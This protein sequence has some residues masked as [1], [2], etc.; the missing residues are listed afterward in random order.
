MGEEPGEEIT[1]PLDPVPAAIVVVEMA[2]PAGGAGPTGW[3]GLAVG[4]ED[5]GPVVG[6]AVP[7]PTE[8]APAEH[9]VLA[10]AATAST[11]SQARGAITFL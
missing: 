5:R 7:V 10:A 2:P 3:A 8:V 11:A 1:G 6:D 9:A 4:K